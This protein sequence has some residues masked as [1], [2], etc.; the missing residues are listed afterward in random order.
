MKRTKNQRRGRLV[1]FLALTAS[2]TL[3][4]AG[5]TPPPAEKLPALVTAKAFEDLNCEEVKNAVD[6]LNAVEKSSATADEEKAFKT[7]TKVDPT[8]KK[9]MKELRKRLTDRRKVACE[10]DRTFT[11]PANE[12]DVHASAFTALVNRCGA[13]FDR[14]SVIAPAKD[15]KA[16]YLLKGRGDAVKSWRDYKCRLMRNP[17]VTDAWGQAL[18]KLKTPSGTSVC[19][20]NSDWLPAALDSLAVAWLET[21]GDKR[22][23]VTQDFQKFAFKV[24]TILELLEKKHGAG[25]AS[26]SYELNV[27][28][29][30]VVRHAKRTDKGYWGKFILLKYTPKGWD[31]SA[32][33]LGINLWDGRPAG[34]KTNCSSHGKLTGPPPGE[35]KVVCKGTTCKPH[36]RCTGTKCKPCKHGVCR[37]PGRNR[38]LASGTTESHTVNK[39]D[40]A[41]DSGGLQAS[42]SADADK[43]KAK[44]EAKEAAKQKAAEEAAKAAGGDSGGGDGDHGESGT[45]GW[46]G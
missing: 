26:W 25:K 3:A 4:L 12:E 44:A 40:G 15:D 39:N 24:I 30:G 18:C 36:E 21:R 28:D 14:S 6:R 2:L 42:P 19:K 10:A 1:A 27:F 22:Q 8:N 20:L 17:T 31:C 29:T 41:T 34:L 13:A 45:P 5:C 35:H 38:G 33:V 9:A 43:A 7:E 32:V 11:V 23:Y 16:S 46:G 37:K